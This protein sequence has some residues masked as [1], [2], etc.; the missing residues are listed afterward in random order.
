MSR[1]VHPLLLPS[2]EE[3]A[4]LRKLFSGVRISPRSID[5]RSTELFGQMFQGPRVKYYIQDLE[6]EGKW[7]H[8]WEG[9]RY[10]EPLM[11]T[12]AEL[13]SAIKNLLVSSTRCQ[14]RDRLGVSRKEKICPCG[15]QKAI[16]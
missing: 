14:R 6:T 4:L 7:A 12:I 10:S 13:Q 5:G 8:F 9:P 11:D 1:R 2:V 15:E 3:H 16:S